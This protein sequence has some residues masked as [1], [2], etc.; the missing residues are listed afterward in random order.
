MTP[1]ERILAALNKNKP[2]KVPI[3]ELE[4]SGVVVKK[5]AKILN[6]YN[7]KSDKMHELNNEIIC[8]YCKLIDKLN[9]DSTTSYPSM[10]MEKIDNTYCRDR[11]G[12]IYRLSEHGEPIP[13]KGPINSF[14]DLKNFDMKSKIKSEDFYETKFIL[15]NVNK[16]KAHFLVIYDPFKLSWR[17]RGSMQNLLMDYVLNPKLIHE[18]T[19]ITTDFNIAIIDIAAEMG[20]DA[21]VMS[22]DLAGEKN[23]IISPKHYREYIKPYHKKIVDHAHNKGLKIIKHSDGNIW[24]ILDDFIEVGFDGIHPIQPQCMDIVEVKKYVAGKTCVLGNIDCLN[25]LTSGSERDVEN[26]VKN[27]IEKAAPGGGFIISSSN[28]IHPECKPQNYIAMIKAVHQCNSK[29]V[30][31]NKHSYN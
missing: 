7:N 28:S 13:V 23:T 9:I 5:I 15:N 17:L 19:L 22:G 12:T 25:L 31:D 10:G 18:L 1:K 8:L 6:L 14:S 24:S 26:A 21:I 20:V 27:L 2:D 4:I 16:S 11:Y 30:Y 29:K 3:F